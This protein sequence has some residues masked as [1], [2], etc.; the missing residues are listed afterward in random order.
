[1]RGKWTV[2]SSEVLQLEQV[3]AYATPSGIRSDPFESICFLAP[4]VEFDGF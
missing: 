4:G 2:H 3:L 1:M